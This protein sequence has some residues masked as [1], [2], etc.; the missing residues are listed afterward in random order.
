[1]REGPARSG[2]FTPLLL[3]SLTQP[4]RPH[5]SA[6][7]LGPA[8]A[9]EDKDT[10]AQPFTTTS[11][12]RP[13][14]STTCRSHYDHAVGSPPPMEGLLWAGDRAGSLP[15]VHGHVDPTAPACAPRWGATSAVACKTTPMAQFH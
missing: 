9:S 10:S 3:V 15:C 13:T 5:R 12:T 11:A 4:R 2:R 8:G 14:G 7:T 1:M 6:G